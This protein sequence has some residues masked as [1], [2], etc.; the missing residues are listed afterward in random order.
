MT[1][2]LKEPTM[3]DRRSA[4]GWWVA[5]TPGT[6]GIEFASLTADADLVTCKACQRTAAFRAAAVTTPPDD[7]VELSVEFVDFVAKNSS[8]YGATARKLAIAL[9]KAWA[10][11]DEAMKER[12]DAW[13]AA[14][15]YRSERDVARSLS[16]LPP[17]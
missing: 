11:R 15:E 8:Q 2:H 16:D 4:C 9:K 1:I 6:P 7:D 10:D 14:D 12:D 5:T 17:A 13:T 3:P